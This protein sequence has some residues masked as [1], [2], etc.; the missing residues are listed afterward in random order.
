MGLFLKTG[1]WST[2][3]GSDT[4]QQ[5]Y[6]CSAWPVCILDKQIPVS[7]NGQMG[8][9]IQVAVGNDRNMSL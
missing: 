9:T 5:R 8:F 7:A 3:K 1:S 4:G 2:E 6:E